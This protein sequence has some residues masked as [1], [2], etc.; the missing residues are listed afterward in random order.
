MILSW[1]SA[2]RSEKTKA[3]Q[4]II[5]SYRNE[6]K[7]HSIDSGKQYWTLAGQCNSKNVWSNGCEPDQLLS[8]DLLQSPSQYYGVEINEEWH[9]ENINA[10]ITLNFI[11]G[12]LYQ[13]IVNYHNMKKFNPA[14][15]NADYFATSKTCSGN[16]SDILYFLSEN[17]YKDVMVVG[18]FCLK[19]YFKKKY[20]YQEFIDNIY[21]Q[22]RFKMAMNYGWKFNQ[23]VFDYTSNIMP[24]GT[25][26]FYRENT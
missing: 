24:M 18:N 10:N 19:E 2:A 5:D 9:K 6:F 20:T 15:I 7:Q 22:P 21:K 3:R 23:K 11:H 25:I 13:Q 26:I 12:D 14:I 8:E 16:F 17:D 1:S 4:Y